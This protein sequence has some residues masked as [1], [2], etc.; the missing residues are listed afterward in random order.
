[1]LTALYDLAVCPVSFDFVT[2]LVRAKLEQQRRGA[3]RLHVLVVPSIGGLAGVARYWGPHDADIT[4]WRLWNLV[5]AACPLARATVTL[6]PAREHYE[7]FV[8]GALW[9]PPGKSY[10]LGDLVDAARAGES[11][12]SLAP[13]SAALRW[14][15]RWTAGGR[16]VTL[17]LRNNANDGRDSSSDWEPF[18]DYLRFNGWRV[19]VLP[20]TRDA[21]NKSEGPFSAL[22]IDLRL[23]LYTTAAMNCFC[24][25]GT[26]VLAWHSRAPYLAFNAALPANPWRAHWEDLLR[27]KTGDQLPWANSN[28]RMIYRPDN[29]GVMVEEFSRWAGI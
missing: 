3:D 12:P 5:M 6:A 8:V 20:D 27:L 4:Y 23:G 18:A 1:M 26:M 16:C 15:S 25:N 7:R 9:A 28:Q 22:S 21:L 19:L 11:I 17:T 29:L 2:W 13:T 24:H 14:A 10:L